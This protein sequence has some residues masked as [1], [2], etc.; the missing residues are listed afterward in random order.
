[1][2]TWPAR[3]A[4]TIACSLIALIGVGAAGAFV[5]FAIYA[6]LTQVMAPPYAALCV[7]AMVLILT[8]LLLGFI[9][10]LTK[11]R[12][13][14]DEPA[15]PASLM[16]IQLGKLVGGDLLALIARNPRAAVLAAI[17][18]GLV[19]GISPRLR[20]TLISFLRR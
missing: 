1:M 16:G 7:A 17:A 14:D 19:V 8:A 20:E 13:Y 4:V 10:L 9:L 18:G 5:C 12:D 3:I 6:F 15:D 11:I 2:N